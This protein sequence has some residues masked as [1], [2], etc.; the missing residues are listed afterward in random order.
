MKR[1]FLL[2]LLALIA[3][4]VVACNTCGCS[5]SSPYL[6]ILSQRG[7]SFLGLQHSYR[8][9]ESYHDASEQAMPPGKEQFQTLQLWGSYAIGRL[10]LLAILP[11]QYNLKQEDG[12]HSR[13]SGLGDAT[14]LVNLQLLKPNGNCGGW[15]QF[16]QAGAG[17]KM[18]TGAY[19]NSV[20]GSGDELAPSMQ[21]GTGSWDY[22]A[23]ANYT[24]RHADWGFN[25]EGSYT[26]TTPNRQTYKYGNRLSSALQAFREIPWKQLRYIPAAGLRF[27][28]AEQDYDNYPSR[29][30][31]AYTGGY[32]LYATAGLHVYSQKWG[33]ELGYN[34]PLTQHYGADL[35]QAKGR[36]ELGILRLF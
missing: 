20:L 2:I 10:R 16:L 26:L 28:Q 29:S 24:L 19:D 22:L 34:L 25:L 9:F 33:A 11:Y 36:L 1:I 3:G 12:V 31:A 6:G 15:Q 14:L 35:V 23:N 17:I 30:R 7:G 21:A 5:A 4:P 18:P 13:L 32:F 8:W 27:E